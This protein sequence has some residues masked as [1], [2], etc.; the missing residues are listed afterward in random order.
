MSAVSNT[1]TRPAAPAVSSF[2]MFRTLTGI[3]LVS[4]CL[5]AGVYEGTYDIIKQNEAERDRKAVFAV[6]P[7]IAEDSD[8]V[9][10]YLNPST[11]DLTRP[12]EGAAV[13]A[14]F[15]RIYAGYDASGGL[16]GVALPAAG[17]GYGGLIRVLYGYAPDK[18]EITGFKVLKSKETPGLG[19]R[20]AKE[21]FVL[22]FNAT[23][24][25]LDGSKQA[26]AHPIEWV[27]AGTKTEPWQVDG[28]AG[29]TISSKAVA[30]MLLESTERLLPAIQARLDDLKGGQDG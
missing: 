12:E 18:E 13:E 2:A 25:A 11:G 14:G 28:I 30:K 7:G 27:K 24:V 21:P 22:G 17:Q 20:I 9:V 29:A 16:V 26:L 4:G 1:E 3:A 10:F 5:L 23:D 8:P 6:L 19:D 15:E